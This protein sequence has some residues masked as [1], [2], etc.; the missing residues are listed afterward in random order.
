MNK[1]AHQ[2]SVAESETSVLIMGAG[3]AGLSAAIRLKQLAA[4][5][6][7]E[8]TVAVVEKGSEVGA[9]ILPAPVVPV[10]LT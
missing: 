9:H 3:P 1:T 4:E 8:L 2:S 10:R 5:S 6:G 7:G